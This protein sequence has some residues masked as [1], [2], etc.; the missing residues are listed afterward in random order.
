MAFNNLNM[1]FRMLI[2]CN[3]INFNI[4][5]IFNSRDNARTQYCPNRYR[6]R[7]CYFE[8]SVHTKA[9]KKQPPIKIYDILKHLIF[10]TVPFVNQTDH[11]SY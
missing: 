11:I 5:K 10:T 3:D 9:I 1:S 7:D 4:M 8:S 2:L 6:L